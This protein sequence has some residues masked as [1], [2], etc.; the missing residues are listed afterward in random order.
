LQIGT[1]EFWNY[2]DNEPMKPLPIPN[3]LPSDPRYRE[4]LVWLRR[5][6]EDY[7]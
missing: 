4:D 5:G 1:E 7:A 3:P 6:N 2:D